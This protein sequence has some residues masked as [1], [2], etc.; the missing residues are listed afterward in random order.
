MP[1]IKAG[2]WVAL[3][4]NGSTLRT[5]LTLDSGGA[6]WDGHASLQSLGVGAD[7]ALTLY[8]PLFLPL[9]GLRAGTSIESAAIASSAGSPTLGTISA[10]YEELFFPGLGVRTDRDAALT[11]A[12]VVRPG[13]SLLELTAQTPAASGPTA[14]KL[15]VFSP[16][17]VAG[18]EGCVR[19][20]DTAHV[21]LFAE[22]KIYEYD[23]ASGITAGLR[24]AFDK[25]PGQ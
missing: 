24:L 25:P 12:F 17:L 15:D 5:P 8:G 16:V 14:Q 22:P 21:C 3:D 10:S 11:M 20:A 4:M 1:F 2:D 6:S 7:T 18:V 23:W 9:V 13:L 19:V